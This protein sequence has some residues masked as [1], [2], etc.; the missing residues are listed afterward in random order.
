VY[1]TG[2]IGFVLMLIY[3]INSF[4]VKNR[5]LHFGFCAGCLLLVGAT[6]A[7]CFQAVRTGAFIGFMDAMLLLLSFGCFL[8]LIYCLFFALPFAETYQKQQ[9]Q[10]SVYSGGVYALCRHP[11]VLCFWGLYLFLGLAALPYKRLLY[12]GLL[13]STLNTAYAWFQ[14]R[15]TFPKSFYDYDEY[16]TIAPFLFPNPR[17]IARARRM[18]GRLHGKE[19]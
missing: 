5:C 4:T 17:S 15:I 19:E 8:A 14:D 2:V 18:W 6:A 7:A 16:R 1:I 12:M 13:F 10:R 11:G 9:N 3:D